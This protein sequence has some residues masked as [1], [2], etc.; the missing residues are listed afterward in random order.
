MLDFRLETFK[1][2]CAAKSYTKTA[3]ILHITQPAVSQHIKFLEEYYGTK[4]VEFQGKNFN[5]TKAGEDLATYISLLQADSKKIKERLAKGSTRQRHLRFGATLSIG[6]YILPP[7]LEK[8]YFAEPNCKITMP[9]E[10]TQHLLEKLDNGEIDFAIIEGYFDKNIYGH[11]VL[12][13]ENF[14]AVSSPNHPLAKGKF[15]IKDL[16][17]HNIIIR[18][19]GSGTRDVL[20]HIL[21]EHHLSITDFKQVMEIGSFKTITDLVAAGIGIT[22]VY[23]AVAQEHLQSGT[24]QKLKV[25]NFQTKRE[26][27]F[28]YLKNSI[29]EKDYLDFYN[30]CQANKRNP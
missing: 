16:L 18:E 14:I 17:E 4:L 9:V 21:A 28:V 5:L 22:F 29:F 19:S 10:N 30:F 25:E 7:I 26:F 11:K 3:Q 8:F 23:E 15:E 6:Q 20:E 12:Q 2:L 27:N 24:L 1:T 13:Q